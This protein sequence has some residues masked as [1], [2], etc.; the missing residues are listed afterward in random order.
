[1]NYSLVSRRL[2]LSHGYGRLGKPGATMFGFALFALLALFAFPAFASAA[3]EQKESGSLNAFQDVLHSGTNTIAVG[4][5]SVYSSNGTTWT[6]TTSVTSGWLYDLA[7]KSDGT[8]YAVGDSAIVKTSSDNG[9]TW[10]TFPLNISSMNLYAVAFGGTAGYMAG[11][12]GTLLYTSSDLNSWIQ[13]S[14]P[15]TTQLNA[16]SALSDSRTAYAVGNGGRL[17][18]TNQG[19]VN[20]TNFGTIV[21]EN[22][23]GVHF[24]D[25]QNGW[26]VGSN[27][28]FLKT[29]NGGTNWSSVSVSGL[30]TQH[31]NAIDGNGQVIVV[32]G[33]NIALRSEDGGVTWASHT[34]GDTTLSLKGA[35]VDASGNAWVAGTKDDVWS[36]V[37]TYEA[38]VATPQ[39]TT[40]VA[41]APVVT[42]PTDFGEASSG[43]LIKTRC[44]ATASVNDPCKA[45]YFL[46]QDGKRH[47]FP[48]ERV[49]FTWYQ[50]FNNIVEVSPAF[51]SSRTLGKNVTYHPGTRMVKFQTSPS[52]YV[53]EKG[54][55]LRPIASEDVARLLYGST[56]NKHIDDIAD[57]FYGNYTYGT[58]VESVSDYDRVAVSAS[59][60]DLNDNF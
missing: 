45:V 39:P 17:L 14:S 8:I 21:N 58:K 31:L 1:M 48:N 26:V 32:A 55:R 35:S 53:V 3:W 6:K 13:A 23:Q 33:D 18:F 51:M 2:P 25:A 16:I 29:T 54:G 5:G 59:V 57:V 50:N 28:A 49:Y 52:V 40:P 4:N 24:K 44:I 27:G 7:R 60:E 30:T 20:W 37:Y 10:S 34:F 11:A 46:S 9:L 43:D 47:A 41:T 38:V 56:W 15:V 42:T 12:D 19:G 36:K 22:L